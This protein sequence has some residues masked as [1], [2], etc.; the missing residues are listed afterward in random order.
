MHRLPASATDR[1]V[2]VDIRVAR[3]AAR[4][5]S[6]I[7][8]WQ[9]L[10]IG[11]SRGAIERRLARGSLLRVHR[12]V[13]LV[14]PPPLSP[15]GRLVAALLACDR[16]TVISHV[17]ALQ[18]WGLAPPSS[19]PVHVTRP[20]RDRLRHPGIVVHAS[21]C[22]G[23]AEVRRRNGLPVTA[24]ARTVIDAGLSRTDRDLLWLV[25]ELRVRRLATAEDLRAALERHPG[26]RGTGRLRRIITDELAGPAFTRSEAERRMLD[27]IRAA[28]LPTP[29]VNAHIA[30]LE[31]DLSW[32]DPRLVVEIDGFGFHASRAAF[33]RDRRRDAELQARGWRV[34]RVTWRRISGEPEQTVALLRRLLSAGPGHPAASRR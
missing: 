13:F 28:G 4:Q 23:P 18:L 22:L 19:G 9:L 26:R 16:G 11:L 21:S 17:S 29:R 6:L 14:G 8:R 2:A 33:E 34:A 27:L 10:A 1:A 12:E 3:V 31:V 25:E 24:P 5:A 20:G 15:S 32:P 30:G 7:A